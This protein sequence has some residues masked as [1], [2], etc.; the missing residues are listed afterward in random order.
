MLPRTQCRCEDQ[1]RLESRLI[2]SA[3]FCLA[4]LVCLCIGMGTVHDEATGIYQP[5]P[6]AECQTSV[7]RT[8]CLDACGCGW[9]QNSD[10]VSEC[11]NRGASVACH[12]LHTNATW[13]DTKTPRCEAEHHKAVVTFDALGYSALALMIIIVILYYKIIQ[14]RKLRQLRRAESD[15]ATLL[16]D[17]L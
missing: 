1:N 2:I 17:G 4:V 9:C 3:I 16:L 5:K 10:P 11:L 14:I 13:D 12:Y 8:S 6:L 7:D 15:S